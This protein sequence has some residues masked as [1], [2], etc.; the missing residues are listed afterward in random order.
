MTDI[1]GVLLAGGLARRMGGGDKPMRKIAGRTILQRVIDRL[2][3][4]CSGLII[5]ANGD[6]ARFAAFGL[7]I[8][9]DDVADHPGPLAGIL[10]ALDWTAANRPDVKWVL[11]AAGDCPFLPRDLAARLEH[12]R[13]AENAE[14]AV[15]S[16]GG[17]VHPVIGLWSVRLR[18][19]LRHALVKEDVRRIDRWTARYPLATVEW[20]IEPLD[21]FFNANTVEDIAEADRLAALDGG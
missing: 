13:A 1:P 18:S 2:A 10:A 5:N 6:P 9:A 17:Q 3:P 20:P 19:E 4:Q 11:S 16:S 15:A 8:I 14:L 12:A 21:P 7:P